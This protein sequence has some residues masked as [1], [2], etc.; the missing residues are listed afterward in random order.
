MAAGHGGVTW[1]TLRGQEGGDGAGTREGGRGWPS[2]A[3][4]EEGRGPPGARRHSRLDGLSHGANLV[5]LQQQAVAG[6]LLNSLGDPLGVGDREVIPHDL[7]VNP[8]EE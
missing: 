3:G 5:D 1:A 8:R 2:R 6:L 4:V 7:D